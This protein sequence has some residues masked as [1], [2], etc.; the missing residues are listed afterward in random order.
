[1]ENQTLKKTPESVFHFPKHSFD[2]CISSNM[3]LWFLTLNLTGSKAN[4]YWACEENIHKRA[5][6]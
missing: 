1:M 6:I 2:I 5:G 4:Y 3:V